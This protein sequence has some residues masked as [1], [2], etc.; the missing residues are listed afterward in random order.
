MLEEIL[1]SQPVQI[2]AGT[3]LAALALVVVRL[4]VKGVIA[5]VSEWLNRDRENR[6]D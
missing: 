3:L 4:F 2:A 1:S 6:T 5:E